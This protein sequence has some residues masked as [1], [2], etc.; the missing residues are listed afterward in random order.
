[1]NGLPFYGAFD[2]RLGLYFIPYQPAAN[3]SQLF[4][5]TTTTTHPFLQMP[6][7]SS[8][9]YLLSLALASPSS[10]ELSC[11]TFSPE[12]I[13]KLFL[14]VHRPPLPQNVRI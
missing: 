10:C 13:I 5:I 4:I 3:A 14:Q 12:G 7:L 8:C 2:S 9:S 6:R 11:G 1:M